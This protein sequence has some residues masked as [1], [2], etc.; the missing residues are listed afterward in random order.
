MEL[1]LLGVGVFMLILAGAAAFLGWDNYNEKLHPIAKV[2]IP[3]LVGVALVSCVAST[4][5]RVVDAQEVGVVYHTVGANSTN[6]LEVVPAGVQIIT[7]IVDRFY[8]Y[9]L[10]QHSVELIGEGDN[11]STGAIRSITSD[12]QQI[13]TDVTVI[14]QLRNDKVIDLHRQWQYS[15]IDG[16]IVPETRA[17][18]RNVTNRFTAEQIYSSG[19]DELEAEVVSA[20]KQEIEEY[21]LFIVTDVLVRDISFTPE[22]TEAVE[23]KQIQEQTAQQAENKIREIEAEAD[24]KRAEAQG[25]ADAAV[26][27]AQGR[28]EARIIEAEAEAQALEEIAGALESNPDLLQYT[29]IKELGDNVEIIILPNNS[30]YLFDFNSLTGAT[31]N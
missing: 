23:Q 1:I 26:I 5:V 7:P 4:G 3:V 20:V 18:V 16:V 22:F 19:R 31:P 17:A 27:A 9:N 11:D 2:V 30:P 24:Q 8:K 10:S 15:Y 25:L 13:R 29:Y 12:G 14:F 28:A 21:G 6:N